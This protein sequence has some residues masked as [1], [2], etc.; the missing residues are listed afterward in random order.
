MTQRRRLRLRCPDTECFGHK[1][2]Y[3]LTKDI[4]LT[5]NPILIVACPYCGKEAQLNLRMHITS[6]D[7][8]SRSVGLGPSTE[9]LDFNQVLDT[10]W[11]PE[12]TTEEPNKDNE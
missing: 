1:E 9:S 6:V 11:L 8:V 5:G 4:D 3:E 10:E 12:E 7:Q 2:P